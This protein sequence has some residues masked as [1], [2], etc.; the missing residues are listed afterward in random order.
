MPNIT[1][2]QFYDYLVNNI[3]KYSNEVQEKVKETT[4][5]VS[6][7]IKPELQSYSYKGHLLRTGVYRNGWR[8]TTLNKNG[9]YRR[10]VYNQKKPTLVHLLEFGHGGPFPAKAYPHV[11]P[12]ERKYQEI[13]FNKIKE[14]VERVWL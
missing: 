10:K 13:L 12:T 5:D 2:D 11:S 6:N 4:K 14:I 3:A 8:V 1:P 7:D 9:V